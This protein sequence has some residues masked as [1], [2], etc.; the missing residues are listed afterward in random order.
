MKAR[1]NYNI[2]FLLLSILFQSTSSI[3]TKFASMNVKAGNFFSLVN[4]YYLSAL[5]CL[6]L[7]AFFWQLTLKKIELSIAYPLT[8][9]NAVFILIF[10]YIIFNEQITFNNIIGVTII[11][12][13]IIIQNIKL[14]ST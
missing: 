1:M 10:S 12:I 3:L 5:F 14:A 2:I 11:M 4:V 9:L 7:Q 6:L 13:G 8:A